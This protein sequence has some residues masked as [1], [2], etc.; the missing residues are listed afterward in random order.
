MAK[1][2][3]G[4]DLVPTE[5]NYEYFINK[6]IETIIGKELKK[7]FDIHD[8]KIFNL[9]VP[10]TQNYTP[11]RKWG[12]N[13]LAPPTT[14][15]GIKEMGIDFVC[16]ANNHILDQGVQ[17]VKSTLEILQ[18]NRI[19]YAGGGMS[20]YDAKKTYSFEL[21][22][23]CIGLY[24]CTEHEFSIAT[25]HSAGANPFDSI[26]SFDHVEQLKEQSDRVIVLYHGGK[27]HFPYPTPYLQKVCRKFIEKGA[28]MVIC[29]HSHCIG[30]EEKYLD[31]TI[32]YGQGN[33]L[34]DYLDI[35]CWNNGL[36][37]SLNVDVDKMEVE[38]IPVIRNRNCVRI[39][40]DNEATELLK[41]FMIRSDCIIEEKFIQ[42]QFEQMAL[43]ESD[44]YLESLKRGV[45]ER[46]ENYINCETHREILLAGIQLRSKWKVNSI[47]QCYKNRKLVIWGTG[48]NGKEVCREMIKCGIIPNLFCDNDKNVWG[49][50]ILGIKCI[51]PQELK[52]RYESDMLVQIAS[53]YEVD[54]AQQLTEL[55]CA[56]YMMYSE[57]KKINGC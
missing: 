30:C 53:M 38:Y 5:S 35:E 13:L 52:V 39:A 37:I 10:L 24:C 11:I 3:I 14:I 19:A 12:V 9:E 54:I 34:F 45:F 16:L 51:S 4:G 56:N 22:N 41:D 32:V 15:N 25:D 26:N 29:Q 2:L 55:G 43:K 20:L 44:M 46:I 6:N 48:D 47:R 23:V 1:I 18:E 50:N 17:G 7:I 40:N 42:A 8:F 49:K 33:F 36:L 31:G 27:E 21:D 57:F 28:D